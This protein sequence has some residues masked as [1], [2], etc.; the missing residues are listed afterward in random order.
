MRIIFLGAPGSGK[1]T[2]SKKVAEQLKIPQLSTGDILRA[3]VKKGTEVGKKAQ[4]IM[5]AGDLVS[6]EIMIN[7]IKNRTA[8]PDCSDGYILDGFPRTLKQSQKLDEMAKSS[9]KKIN[10]V[11]SLEVDQS[12]LVTR[13]TG[14][15]VCSVCGSEY[16]ILFKKPENEGFCDLDGKG[17]IHR[18]DDHEDRIVTRLENYN[19]QTTPLIEY[20][21]QKGILHNIDATGEIDDIKNKILFVLR[22]QSS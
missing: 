5:E 17:L 21:I 15:R 22:S 2:Q 16:H 18:S 12:I 11:I 10:K 8:E 14:R 9:G 19:R 3:A 7:I 4:K 1:G 20:Y 6:D 13:L